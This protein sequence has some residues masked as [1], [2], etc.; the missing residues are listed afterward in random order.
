M[1]LDEKPASFRVVLGHEG[2]SWSSDDA[3]SATLDAA[4]FLRGAEKRSAGDDSIDGANGGRR[5]VEVV[6]KGDVHWGFLSGLV[7]APC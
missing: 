3:T 2:V 4:K 6:A 7:P 5:V 1:L